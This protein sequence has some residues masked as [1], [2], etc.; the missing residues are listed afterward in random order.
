M[1]N[2]EQTYAVIGAAMTVH[3]K[4]GSGF[5]EAVYQEALEREFIKQ[6]IPY[7]RELKLPVYYDGVR[8]T[9]IIRL[10]SSVMDL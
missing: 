8:L 6:N 4:L 3:A 2:D 10:T 7:S 5:L 9:H 1:Q